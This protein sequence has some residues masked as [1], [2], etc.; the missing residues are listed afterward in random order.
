MFCKNCGVKVN[1]GACFCPHCGTKLTETNPV[2]KTDPVIRPVLPEI[3]ETPFRRVW[4]IPCDVPGEAYRHPFTENPASRSIAAAVSLL[5]SAKAYKDSQ[6]PYAEKVDLLEQEEKEING[7]LSEKR[8]GLAGCAAVLFLFFFGIFKTAISCYT[9]SG[10]FGSMPI[11]GTFL[12]LISLCFLIPAIVFTVRFR[13]KTTDK[14]KKLQRLQKIDQEIRQIYAEFQS[15]IDDA[16]SP[17][18]I[19]AMNYAWLFPTLNVSV[20]Q[21]SHMIEALESGRAGTFQEALLNYDRCM[22]EIKMENM[23]VETAEYARRSAEAAERTAES[24]RAAAV[25]AASMNLTLSMA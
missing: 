20:Y 21:I 10:I 11:T 2:E 18:R 14:D 8:F 22:H 23:A 3:P 16:A 17:V 1:E 5:R 9:S 7:W 24:A 19:N 12:L 13:K 15:R 4:V 25:A 6:F